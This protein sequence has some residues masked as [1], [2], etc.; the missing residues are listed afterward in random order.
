VEI[1]Y[2]LSIVSAVSLVLCL[3]LLPWLVVRLPEDYFARERRDP[4][5]ADRSLARKLLSIFRCLIGLAF[6]I[7]GALLVL[8]P[9]Q[10]LLTILVGVLVAEFPGKFRLERNL[11]R[12]PGVR[13]ALDRIRAAF[14]HPPLRHE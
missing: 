12:R 3:G 4:L 11:A 1:L 13:S 2:V 7:I 5:W 8:L 10:G 6:V 9:G 14:D